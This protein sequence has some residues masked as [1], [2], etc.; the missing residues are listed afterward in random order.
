MPSL[1]A[2]PRP[3][4]L[5]RQSGGWARGARPGG[6][7]GRSRSR[8]RASRGSS[9]CPPSSLH[10]GLLIWGAK[11]EGGVEEH[12]QGDG[13]PEVEEAVAEHADGGGGAAAQDGA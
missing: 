5:G 6:G 2:T 4:Y 9:A 12:G 7:G 1:I 8:R 10:P 3:S 13:E 11:A